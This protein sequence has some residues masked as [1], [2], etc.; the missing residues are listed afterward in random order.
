MAES[1]DYSTAR[2]KAIDDQIAHHKAEIKRLTETAKKYPKP[3]A[4]P[5]GD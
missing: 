4:T 1:S 5:A 3:A 2:R